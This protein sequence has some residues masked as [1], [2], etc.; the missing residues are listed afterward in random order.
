LVALSLLALAAFGAFAA[1][2]VR[3]RRSRGSERRQLKLFCTGVG[4]V[5]AVFVLPD[6]PL[7]LGGEAA[8]RALAFVGLLA[9]PAAV[10]IALLR[11]SG[12]RPTVRTS[13]RVG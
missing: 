12:E 10:A 8:Q 4:I 5:F 11:P 1:V 2:V 9:L 3:T 13:V 6:E 7:G